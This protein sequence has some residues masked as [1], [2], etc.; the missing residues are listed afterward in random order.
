LN[1][2]ETGR[3]IVKSLKSGKVYFVE[4]IQHGRPPQWGD[5]D[6]AAKKMTGS[7]G[8]KYIG[9]VKEENSIITESNGFTAISLV[10][11]SPFSEIERR[12]QAYLAACKT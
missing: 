9:A 5:I 1:R 8:A 6:L 12:D 7:Y 4:P 11:G 10:K 3:F 2:D